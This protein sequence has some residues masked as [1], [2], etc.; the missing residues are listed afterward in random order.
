MPRRQFAIDSRMFTTGPRRPCPRCGHAELATLSIMNNVHTRRCGSC[1]RDEEELLPPLAK[2]MIYLDQMVISDIAKKLDPVWRAEKPHVDDFWLEAFDRIDRLVKLQLIVC[3]NS[4]IHE[5]ESSLA[6]P[7]ATVL[8]RLYKH[9]ASGVSL[10]FPHQVYMEQLSEAFDAWSTRRHPDW[11]RITRAN[12]IRGDLYRWSD[13]LRITADMG[14]SPGEIEDRRQS[15]VHAHAALERLWKKWASE[16]QIGFEERFE[17]E[18]RG[19]A[20]AALSSA[21]KPAWLVQLVEWLLGRLKQMGVP[22]ETRLQKAERFLL[23]EQALCAPENHLGALLHASLARRAADG[24]KCPNQGTP[25]DL[26]FIAAYLPYC[27]AMFIDRQFD[28]LLEQG[29]LRDAVS[30]YPTMIF[31]A[32]SR[33]DF[34]AYLDGLEAEADP[35]HVDLVVRTYGETWTEPYRTMLEHERGRRATSS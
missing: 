22:R 26:K 31:S 29:S 35:G 13:R 4:P 19:I 10:R 12:V 15:R 20:E 28:H 33:D 7:Y 2:R 16:P 3:P 24:Q 14:R 23:S 30:D 5:V 1:F 8:R 9:L 25:S 18:R 11:R 34:L 32:R 27:D 17:I 6:V 21:R